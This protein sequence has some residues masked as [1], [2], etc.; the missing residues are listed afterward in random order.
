MADLGF[1]GAPVPEKYGG[2][3]IDKVAIMLLVEELSRGSSSVRTTVSVQTSL[4]ETSLL[5]F[6]SEEPKKKWL[7]PLAKGTT[8][9]PWALPQP[10]A[11]TD[12]GNL[13]TTAR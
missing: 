3:G 12:G 1:L 13:R 10:Q 7:G 9:G 2:A 11:G 4:S 5:W 8:F 6:G